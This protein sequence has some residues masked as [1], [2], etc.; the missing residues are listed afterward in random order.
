MGLPRPGLSTDLL[1][2][3]RIRKLQHPGAIDIAW[4]ILGGC[5]DF[6]SCYS[7]RR[8]TPVIKTKSST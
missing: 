2:K 7:E 1:R 8:N 4:K 5:L 3:L 6:R